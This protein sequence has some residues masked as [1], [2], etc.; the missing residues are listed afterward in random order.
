MSTR[1]WRL[2]LKPFTSF[3][4]PSRSFSLS[5]DR[6]WRLTTKWY[7][8]KSWPKHIH[9]I[10][11]SFLARTEL[12]KKFRNFIKKG[13]I[14][15]SYTKQEFNGVPSSIISFTLCHHLG[16]FPFVNNICFKT[17][18]PGHELVHETDRYINHFKLTPFH[19]EEMQIF[20]FQRR[21]WS[22]EIKM[23]NCFT[24]CSIVYRSDE[25]KLE[26]TSKSF[27]Q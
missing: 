22:V 12:N 7:L 21:V 1:L 16:L 25:N 23:V 10:K 11:N 19:D 17:L 6:T 18:M 26:Y 27:D 15:F 20:V 13:R 4:K 3:D 24:N 14:C 5:E 9:S 8:E 2:L